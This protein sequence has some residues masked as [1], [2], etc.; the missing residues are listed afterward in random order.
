MPADRR[1]LAGTH[2]K[3]KYWTLRR[4]DDPQGSGTRERFELWRKR[5]NRRARLSRRINRRMA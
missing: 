5:K 2:P 1:P 3:F 4:G